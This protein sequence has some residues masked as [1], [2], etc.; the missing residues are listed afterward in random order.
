MDA[1]FE[2][3]AG[4]WKSRLPMLERGVSEKGIYRDKGLLLTML[5]CLEWSMSAGL[6][7]SMRVSLAT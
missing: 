5:I 3:P 2:V 1:Q 7:N 4:H 6:A